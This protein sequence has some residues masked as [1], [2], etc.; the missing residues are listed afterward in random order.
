MGNKRKSF[1]LAEVLITLT[2]IGVIAVM[3]IPNLM[4]SWKKHQ[5]EVGVKEAY[6]IVSNVL[7]I[8]YA[9]HGNDVYKIENQN[10]NSWVDNYFLPYVKVAKDYKGIDPYTTFFTKKYGS[11]SPKRLGCVRNLK[12]EVMNDGT[13]CLW[14]FRTLLLSNG[15]V[16]NIG[17][18][19]DV[20]LFVV[21]INGIEKGD[22]QNGADI[23][24]FAIW[25]NN[26]NYKLNPGYTRYWSTANLAKTC[27]TKE[28]ESKTGDICTFAIQKNGWKIPDD[29]TVKKF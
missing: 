3:T 5:V 23:F 2:I 4:Q 17:T 27:T 18:Y 26:N 10:L 29:Y 16:I 28:T 21:D 9:E 25:E 11:A 12:G 15:M 19:V 13:H 8:A 6:S 20:R 7:K 14:G 1:T 22:A 24:Q